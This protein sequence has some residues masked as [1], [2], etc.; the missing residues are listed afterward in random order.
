MLGTGPSMTEES[1]QSVAS[2]PNAVSLR[3][4]AFASVCCAPANNRSDFTRA[5]MS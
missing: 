1:F 4:T 5:S 2:N 3:Y